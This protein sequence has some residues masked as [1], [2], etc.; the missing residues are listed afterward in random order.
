M[1]SALQNR[2]WAN[3]RSLETHSTDRPLA[4]ARSLKVRTLVA[5]TGVSTEGKMFSNSALPR[6]CSLVTVP[7]SVPVSLNQWTQLTL[8]RREDPIQIDDIDPEP[9]PSNTFGEF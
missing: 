2:L 6:N 3:G 9:I 7:R 8:T 1:P 5:H 4:A